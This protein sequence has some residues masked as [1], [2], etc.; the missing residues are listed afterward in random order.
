VARRRVLRAAGWALT[1]SGAVALALAAVIVHETGSPPVDAGSL[2]SLTRGAVPAIHAVQ[3]E[4]SLLPG[5]AIHRAR[6]VDLPASPSPPRRVRI[7][8][9]G[10]AARI[11]PVGVTPGSGALALPPDP[12]LVAWYRFGAAPGQAGSAVLAAHVDFNGRP[13]VFF[14]LRRLPVGAR[15][16]VE[17]AR[18]R[19]HR[20]T[21]V[22]RRSYLKRRLPLGLIFADRGRAVLTLVT[23]GGAFDAAT[24]HYESNVVVFA[25]PPTGT[26][27]SR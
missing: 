4:R 22:A 1:G 17:D 9:I 11:V 12:S 10:L 21:V 25:L 14:G 3:S 5:V 8:S 23:C 27:P 16:I 15:V 18:G 24:R 7:P 20:F 13:G 6:L 26:R 19:A 2:A